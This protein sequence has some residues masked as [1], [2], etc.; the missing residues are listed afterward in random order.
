MQVDNIVGADNVEWRIGAHLSPAWQTWHEPPAGKSVRRR[1]AKRLSI[2]LTP[3][4]VE[5]GSE[6]FEA[7]ANDGKEPSACLG[8]G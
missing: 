7:F 2:A 1:H 8:Q 6:G 4:R 5:N 3:D